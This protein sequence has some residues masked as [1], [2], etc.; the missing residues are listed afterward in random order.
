MTKILKKL[1]LYPNR[2]Q[3]IS[4]SGGRSK[5]M[6]LDGETLEVRPCKNTC[7]MLDEDWDIAR[8]LREWYNTFHKPDASVDPRQVI[9]LTPK[10][11]TSRRMIRTEEIDDTV[12]YFDYVGQVRRG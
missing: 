2:K 9:S 7:E 10:E 12:K 6:F 1:Q 8:V 11:K 5:W 3:G 4:K